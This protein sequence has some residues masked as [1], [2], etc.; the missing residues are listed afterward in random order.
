MRGGIIALPRFYFD[1]G[2]FVCGILIDAEEGGDFWTQNQC[3][4]YI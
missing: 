3:T 2:V 4:L 1:R